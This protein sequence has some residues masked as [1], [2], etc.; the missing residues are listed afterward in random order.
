MMLLITEV[1]LVHESIVRLTFHSHESGLPVL[2]YTW[3]NKSG[4]LIILPE[5]LFVFEIALIVFLEM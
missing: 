4:F 1:S 2:F 5:S 3:C